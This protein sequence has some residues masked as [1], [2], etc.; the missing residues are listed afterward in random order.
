[1]KKIMTV[2]LSLAFTAAICVGCGSNKINPD[3]TQKLEIYLYNA[4]YGYKWCEDLLDAFKEEDWVKEK[5]PDLKIN[6]EKDEL[7]T[8][9]RELMTASKKVNKYEIVMGSSLEGILTPDAGVEDLTESVYNSEVPGENGVL[10]KDKLIPSFLGSAVYVDK[11]TQ[12]SSNKYYQ[13]NWGGGM[14]GLIYNE[15]RLTALGFAVPNTTDELVNIMQDVKA[16]GGSNPAY[17]Q[18]T[19]LV[20]YGASAYCNYLYYTWW[21]QYQTVEEY[22]NFYNGIDSGTMSRS[23]EIFRQQ[24]LLKSME[25]LENMMHRDNGLTWLNP[26]TGRE[27]YRETQN[28]L[29]RGDGLFMANGDWVDNELASFREGL[30]KVNGRA[31][32]VK[33]MRTPVISAIIE[34]T[35]SIPDDATLS[36]VVK[37]V[38]NG[39]T[40]YPGVSDE[41][42]AA[43]VAAR[44]VVY[45]IGP[46]H[47]AYIPSYAS[48]KEVAVDF[49]RFMATDKAIEIYIR[50]TNGAS[51]PFQYNLKEKNPELFDRIS[52]LQ[53]SRLNYFSEM[54]VNIL[55]SQ[56]SF[57]L[58]RYGGL[59]TM[60]TGSPLTEFTGGTG[61]GSY[62]SVSEMVFEREYKYW[63]ENN[64]ANWRSVLS[65]AGL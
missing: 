51:L 59:S 65:Q 1:M 8:R 40:G 50:S 6:F 56:A 11:D 38:D 57:P 63:T 33:M 39:Q 52:P 10:Y 2:L 13:I 7:Q 4:G 42:F 17:T 31:D 9:A 47:N 60:A 36:E 29:Q 32:T 24:G 35:P 46:G 19:S 54:N 58:V 23:P 44:N 20:T 64:N 26:S 30:I 3:D 25:V 41:D 45:S 15:D 18:T 48:G 55:P 28:R 34:R 22:V 61:K 12:S 37:A 53:Q 27:A 62:D 16:L 21:A 5:Y 43:I 14:T 49:L